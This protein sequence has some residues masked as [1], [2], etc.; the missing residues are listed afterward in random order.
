MGCDI[1]LMV[2]YDTASVRRQW[3]HSL[4]DQRR[5]VTPF[6]PDARLL[7]LSRAPIDMDPHYGLFAAL[8]GVRADEDFAPLIA[9]RGIPSNCCGEVFAAFHLF[10]QDRG[11]DDCLWE[12]GIWRDQAAAMIERGASVVSERSLRNGCFAITDP[13]FHSASWLTR[14]EIVR[15]L[16]HADFDPAELCVGFRIVLDALRTLDA[17]YGAGHSRIVFAFDS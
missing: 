1:H 11:E 17:E 3:G 10:V 9:P 7:P 16:R 6:G 4:S 12:R 2:E 8:A 14:D 5:P 13:E 15:C